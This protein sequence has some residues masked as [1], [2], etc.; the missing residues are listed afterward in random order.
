VVTDERAHAWTEI[1]Y[2][3]FGF[4]PVDMTPGAA[5]KEQMMAA[6]TSA[7]KE[8][9]SGEDE[10][11]ENDTLED[12]EEDKDSGKSWFLEE[13]TEEQKEEE[14]KTGTEEE[15]KALDEDAGK[16]TAGD[17]NTG[18]EN[19]GEEDTGNGSDG[20]E[21]AGKEALETDGGNNGTMTAYGTEEE[22]SAEIE[23]SAEDDILE[24]V[25]ENT[26]LLNLKTVGK[27]ILCLV[28]MFVLLTAGK[29]VYYKRRY[30]KE[31]KRQSR[32]FSDRRRREVIK[33][34][35][36]LYESM[37]LSGYEKKWRKKCKGSLTD[38]EYEVMIRKEFS[39][40][41]DEYGEFQKLVQKARFASPE[42]ENIISETEFAQCRKFVRLILDALMEKTG[43]YKRLLLRLLFPPEGME[44]E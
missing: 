36:K 24:T 34:S 30:R 41:N 15:E 21:T 28:A 6:G 42:A 10:K 8:T 29:L 40:L 7:K 13:E 39:F 43:W 31:W 12:T 3:G 14:E 37:E 35:C 25:R 27:A 2:D 23:N 9:I 16:E 26:A 17:E 18:N 19:T 22:K 4:M 5:V 1:Y 20:D 33:L 11:E 38:R 32:S 44:K